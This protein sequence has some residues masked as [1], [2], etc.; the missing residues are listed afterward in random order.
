[1]NFLRQM[2][3][4]FVSL[5]SNVVFASPCTEGNQSQNRLLKSCKISRIKDLVSGGELRDINVCVSVI[6]KSGGPWGGDLIP[7]YFSSYSYTDAEGEKVTQEFFSPNGRHNFRS[8]IDYTVV[9]LDGSAFYMESHRTKY[10]ANE[11]RGSVERHEIDF[12]LRNGNLKYDY[13]KRNGVMVGRWT[14]QVAFEAV[15]QE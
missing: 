14:D 3:F 10:P 11:R 4:A 15:C 2:T 6:E 1:M 12:D 9:E 7:W 8:L 5:I 13:T